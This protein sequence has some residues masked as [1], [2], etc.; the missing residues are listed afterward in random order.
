M[1]IELPPLRSRSGDVPLLARHFLEEAQRRSA[2][3]TVSPYAA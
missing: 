1:A 3:P 2:D